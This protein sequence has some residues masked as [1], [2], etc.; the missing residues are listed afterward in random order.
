MAK[1][2]ATVRL[3][4]ANGVTVSVSKEKADRL[5]A[6]GQFSASTSKA[7]TAKKPD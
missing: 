3:T 4:D 6:G 7:S 2:N 5:I 1:E